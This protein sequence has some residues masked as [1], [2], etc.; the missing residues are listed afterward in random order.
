MNFPKLNTQVYLDGASF[1]EML[2]FHKEGF[3]K[4]FT[5]NPTLMAK[6][7]I[8]DYEGF[9]KKV[10]AQIPDMPISFEV[11][12]DDFE[13]M[14]RQ[15]RIIATW[16]KNVNVKIPVS[17]SKGE[18]AY[19]LIKRLSA[20]GLSLNVTAIFTDEQLQ[21][22]HD[23]LNPQA[24]TIIS[25]FAGR[26]ADTGVDP[27]PVMSRAVKMYKDMPKAKILWASPREALNIYQASQCGCHVITAT[28]DLIKK[29]AFHGKSL[30]DF[31]RET[32]KMFYD[33]GQKAGFKL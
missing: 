18:P 24:D 25:I 10:L 2:K 20:S 5:T 16:G 29:L 13:N 27:M 17:N 19:G 14:E 22:V 31:S 6:A 11:F 30:T 1:E 8:T 28:G 3:V 26:I 15:A 7:G 12:S 32:V 33:D 21:H 23:A 9:A 4:G